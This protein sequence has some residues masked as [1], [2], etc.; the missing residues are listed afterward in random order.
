MYKCVTVFQI[1]S[2]IKKFAFVFFRQDFQDHPPPTP[3]PNLPPRRSPG[4]VQRG[5]VPVDPSLL[6]PLPPL[7]P[8][9]QQPL[10]PLGQQPFPQ[11]QGLPQMGQGN[12]GAAAAQPVTPT[13][14]MTMAQ[15]QNYVMH[16]C[17]RVQF[18]RRRGQEGPR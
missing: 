10:Q 11:G 9:V 14:V 12:A 5:A 4:L 1:I 15:L 6:P 17:Q 13:P 16:Q 3:V 2:S 18:S 7:Q 8:R